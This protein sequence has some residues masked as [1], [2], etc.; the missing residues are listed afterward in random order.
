M[1][2]VGATHNSARLKWSFS[3][4]TPASSNSEL[5]FCLKE[6]DAWTNAYSG[7]ARAF[8]VVR[9]LPD[10]TYVFSV[11]ACVSSEFGEWSSAVEVTTLPA[12]HAPLS[13]SFSESAAPRGLVLHWTPHPGSDGEDLYELQLRCSADKSPPGA[14]LTV[15]QSANPVPLHLT[16]QFSTVYTGPA[17]TAELGNLPSG[18]E[19]E[20]RIRVRSDDVLGVFGPVV[21]LQLPWEIQNVAEPSPPS[22]P[23]LP[24]SSVPISSSPLPPAIPSQ[25]SGLKIRPPTTKKPA[26][27][28]SCVSTPL[29]VT[30]AVFIAII[31]MLVLALQSGKFT[32]Y[33]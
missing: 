16:T 3:K 10:S 14:A 6:S 13:L 19:L 5:R 27:Q 33:S 22:F 20:G 1:E 9:L 25:F 18:C 30:L 21:T 8:K 29:A 32:A 26:K 11:R 4:G 12:P 15:A 23:T 2:I 24:S 7:P 28:A 17:T 31:S